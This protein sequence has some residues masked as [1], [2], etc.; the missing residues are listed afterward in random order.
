MTGTIDD[1][2]GRCYIIIGLAS[3]QRLSGIIHDLE[4]KVLYYHCLSI[5][6]TNV[7]DY[8]RPGGVGLIFIVLASAQQMP[9]IIDDLEGR[10][11][12]IILLA[13][14]ERLSEIVHDLEE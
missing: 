7:Q 8:K 2:E 11:Y 6:P 9:G 3:A 5:R 1:L 14:A 12:L 13:S 10:C 4:G